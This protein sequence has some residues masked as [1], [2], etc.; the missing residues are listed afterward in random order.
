VADAIAAAVAICWPRGTDKGDPPTGSRK[1]PG[2]GSEHAWRFS[3]R[4]W[5]A[6]VSLRRDRPWAEQA[7]R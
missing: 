2:G 6:P 5:H 4:W 1:L 7:W 3:G